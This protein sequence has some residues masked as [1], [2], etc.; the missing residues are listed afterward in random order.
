MKDISVIIVNYNVK[1]FIINLIDSVNKARHNFDVEII[2]VDNN[3]TDGS[4]EVIKE[5]YPDVKLIANKVNLGFG[6]ANNQALEIAQGKYLLLINPDTIVR[7]DTFTKIIDF[8]ERTPDVGITGC[9]VLNPDGS[10]QLPCRRSFPGLWTSFTKIIGLSSLFPKSRMFARYN[11][12]YLD[13]NKTYEVDAVSGSFMFLRRE[14]YEKTKGFDPDYF[15][16]GEDLDLCFRTQKAGFKVMYFHETEII[17]YKGESTKRSSIDETK[18][19]YDAMMIFVK[20]HLSTS[21][22]IEIILKVA[23]FS[24]FLI[25]SISR[26]KNHLL[27]GF[28]DTLVFVLALL[29]MEN[30]YK[31]VKDWGGFP[32]ESKPFVYILPAVLQILVS[33]TSGSY[34]KKNI[35]VLK[36]WSSLLVGFVIITL[37]TFFLRQYAYSRVVLLTTYGLAAAGGLFIRI[38]TKLIFKYGISSGS[39]KKKTVIVGIDDKALKIADKFNADTNNLY[40]ITGFISP[41]TADINK[42]IGNHKVIGTIENIVK[43]ADEEKIENVIFST[44]NISFDKIFAIISHL[45]GRNIEFNITGSEQDYV[46][47][48]SGVTLLDSISLVN[49]NYNI[50]NISHKAL[51]RCFDLGFI[52][53]LFPLILILYP[54]ISQRLLFLRKNFIK[55]VF[56]VFTG[57]FSLVGPKEGINN[58]ELFLG[59]PGITGLWLFE[60]NPADIERINIYYAKN[61]NIWL[62]IEIIGRTFARLFFE[63]I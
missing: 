19:F 28:A 4:P 30:Y 57:K 42:K 23:I 40:D 48:K 14:V 60:K 18:I 61:Q 37:L 47:S 20:K 34:S 5:K 41:F 51:K 10:L 17:H 36:Y 46:V 21:L 49:I 52:I 59:K 38:I 54:F 2:I 12:T 27:F 50:T 7:E 56:N 16:Y 53:L 31:T 39:G 29:W 58:S 26:I 35:S 13:E 33:L 15:M 62:D 8:M 11:L 63:R 6:K 44:N 55:S 25:A 1:E 9:K 3:S 43:I 45:Q 22:F 32:E 24:R